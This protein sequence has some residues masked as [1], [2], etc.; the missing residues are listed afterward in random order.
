MKKL[1]LTSGIIACMACPAFANPAE[2]GFTPSQS[3]DEGT[4][5]AVGECVQPSIGTYS[6]STTLVAQWTNDFALMKLNDNNGNTEESGGA[7]THTWDENSTSIWTTSD[8]YIT[9][10]TDSTT[11]AEQGKV[12]YK[13]D[14]N[15]NFNLQALGASVVN[16]PTGAIVKYTVTTTLPQGATGSA[17][18]VT[19]TEPTRPFRG[20]FDS[21]ATYLT[22]DNQAYIDSTGAVTSRGVNANYNNAAPWKALY[23]YASPDLSGDPTAYGYAFQGWVI[24]GDTEHIK[25]TADVN[26]SNR[27][28]STTAVAQWQAKTWDVTFSCGTGATI[29]NAPSATTWT[30]DDTF[31]VPA[32]ADTTV[33]GKAG[34]HFTGW[35]CKQGNNVVYEPEQTISNGS[36]TSMISAS[37]TASVYASLVDDVANPQSGMTTENTND[38]VCTAQYVANNINITW[39]GA[40]EDGNW[41][42]PT[43]GTGAGVCTYGSDVT[44]PANPTRTGY[45]FNGWSVGTTTPDTNLA[46]Q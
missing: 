17:S 1:F 30:F 41:E 13:K 42:A 36:A 7:T 44:I 39:D 8:L 6:G 43:P 34:S 27:T 22:N 5:T 24:G 29:N 31:T 33:C 40:G 9:G 37:L 3:S 23:G 15:N 16:V 10:L 4:S 20:Y 12:V 35:Q 28:E 18:T 21:S 25:S 32:N 38:I 11:D 46:T 26:S 14:A 19:S 2:S 45:T